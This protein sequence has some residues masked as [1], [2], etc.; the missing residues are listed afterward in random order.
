MGNLPYLVSIFGMSEK[1]RI[2][3]LEK[4]HDGIALADGIHFSRINDLS[5]FTLKWR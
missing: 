3:L 4:Y 2:T 1:A 5:I